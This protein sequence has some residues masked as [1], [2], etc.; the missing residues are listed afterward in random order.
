MEELMTAQELSKLL[1]ASQMWPYRTAKKGLIPHYRMGDLVREEEEK[2][3]IE[4]QVL[5]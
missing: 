2:R 3:Y 4:G 1:K 5:V